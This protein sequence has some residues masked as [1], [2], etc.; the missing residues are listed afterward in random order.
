M[1]SCDLCSKTFSSHAS[2]RRHRE[3]HTGIKKFACELCGNSYTQKHNLTKH[4]RLHT[5]K[6]S[7]TLILYCDSIITWSYITRSP[8]GSQIFF[9]YKCVKM[10]AEDRGIHNASCENRTPGVFPSQVWHQLIFPEAVPTGHS[11][12]NA[13]VIGDHV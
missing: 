9:Q 8:R 2:M 1:H 12:Y 11:I 7:I 5:G 10:S 4:M 13:Y 3:I 6:V